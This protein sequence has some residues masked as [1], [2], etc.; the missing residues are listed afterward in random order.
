MYG[1]TIGYVYIVYGQTTHSLKDMAITGMPAIVNSV[2]TP[3]I[4][5]LVSKHLTQQ[6]S[7]GCFYG[8]PHHYALNLLASNFGTVTLVHSLDAEGIVSHDTIGASIVALRLSVASRHIFLFSQ[9]RFNPSKLGS[10]D[11]EKA[12]RKLPLLPTWQFWQ[13]KKFADCTLLAGGGKTK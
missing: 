11:A 6:P 13:G 12:L 1:L 5:L 7:G 10:R 3:P 9:K 4:C 8:S 2:T